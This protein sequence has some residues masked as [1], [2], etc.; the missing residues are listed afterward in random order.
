[1]TDRFVFLYESKSRRAIAVWYCACGV[2]AATIS[3]N[4]RVTAAHH[5]AT[6]AATAASTET[7]IATAIAT[8]TATATATAA[9]T[10]ATTNA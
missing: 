4:L 8:A 1:M 7:A 6:A 2:P 3:S 5:T 9:A 10:A